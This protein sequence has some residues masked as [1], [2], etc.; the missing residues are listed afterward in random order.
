MWDYSTLSALEYLKRQA[1][2]EMSWLKIVIVTKK[3][4]PIIKIN[5]ISSAKTKLPSSQLIRTILRSFV[6]VLK[7]H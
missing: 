5:E 7:T 6:I 1:Q 4:S 3:G 2:R